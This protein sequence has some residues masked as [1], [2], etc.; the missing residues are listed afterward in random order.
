MEE[1]VVTVRKFRKLSGVLVGKQRLSLKQWGK[2]YHC[3][4]R[5]VLLYYC[6]IWQLTGA[7][8][9]CLH[10]VECLM[11]RMMCGVKL[12]NRVLTDA[13]CDRVGVVKIKD[14]IIQSHLWWYGCVIH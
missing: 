14:K 12:V 11:I 9:A 2:I 5:P 4:V 13:L 7:G 6:E 3:S 8:E 10:G 1:L